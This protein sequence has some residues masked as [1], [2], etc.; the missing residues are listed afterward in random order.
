MLRINTVLG[1]VKFEASLFSSRARGALAAVS[2]AEKLGRSRPGGRGDLRQA[3]TV[4][5]YPI[6]ASANPTS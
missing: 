4:S 3:C 6:K 5:S 2:G 1:L